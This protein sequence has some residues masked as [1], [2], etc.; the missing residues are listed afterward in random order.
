VDSMNGNAL[1]VNGQPM[2]MAGAEV[3]GT[4]SVGVSVKVDGYFDANGIFIVTRIEF[5]NDDSGSGSN[6]NSNENNNDD[7]DSNDN[8][9]GDDDN[10]DNS[11]K[12]ENDDDSSDD[13]GG[14][15]D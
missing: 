1:V 5:R 14:D 13:N 10:D 3:R 9:G 2:N 11:G 4:P 6:S 15:D 12:D 7:D 8:D